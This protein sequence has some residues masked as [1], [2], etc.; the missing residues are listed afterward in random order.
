MLLAMHCWVRRFVRHGCPVSRHFCY[1]SSAT[2][3]S[4]AEASCT[5]PRYALDW[6]RRDVVRAGGVFLGQRN[7]YGLYRPF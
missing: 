6:G 3:P 1:M 2:D 7:A 4:L 5:L